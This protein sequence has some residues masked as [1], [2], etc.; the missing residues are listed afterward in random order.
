M[1]IMVIPRSDIE[2]R[3]PAWTIQLRG[4]YPSITPTDKVSGRF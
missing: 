3:F 4:I 1:S 2:E